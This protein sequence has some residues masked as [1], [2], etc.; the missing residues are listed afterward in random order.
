MMNNLG[1]QSSSV[2]LRPKRER[3]KRSCTECR[4]RKQRVSHNPH[5][6]PRAESCL[7]ASMLTHFARGSVIKTNLAATAP[8]DFPSPSASTVATGRP[9]HPLSSASGGTAQGVLTGRPRRG[10]KLSV[11]S[12][13][14]SLF[15]SHLEDDWAGLDDSQR[16]AGLPL[17]LASTKFNG[18]VDDDAQSRPRSLSFSRSDVSSKQVAMWTYANYLSLLDDPSFFPMPH[19]NE[20][21]HICTDFFGDGTGLSMR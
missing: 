19:N 11:P 10:G 2:L 5:Q 3:T 18:T 9:S 13:Y 21:L 17:L 12:Y 15:R 14:L 20:L 6:A 1:G 4:R 8:V 16:H 7:P